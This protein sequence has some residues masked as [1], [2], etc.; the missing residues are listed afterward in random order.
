MYGSIDEDSIDYGN[1]GKKARQ[2]E[3]KRKMNKIYSPLW[4]ACIILSW[5]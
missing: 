5:S 2:L 3:K 1:N 4:P